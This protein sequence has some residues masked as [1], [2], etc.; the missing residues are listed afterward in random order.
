MTCR[1]INTLEVSVSSGTLASS[2]ERRSAS[3]VR[4]LRD[5]GGGGELGEEPLKRREIRRH[6]LQ[7]EIDLARQ[8]PALAHQAASLR[9]HSSKAARSDSA[10]LVRC[11]MANTVTS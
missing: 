6:A 4:M 7:D 2:L 8:H 5:V 9:T 11:T 1:A 10:W 3:A